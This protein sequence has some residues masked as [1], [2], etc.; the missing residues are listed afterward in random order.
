M[1]ISFLLRLVFCVCFIFCLVIATLVVSSSDTDCM[2]RLVSEMSCSVL[3]G[4]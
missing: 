1:A 4:C 3:R 2:E